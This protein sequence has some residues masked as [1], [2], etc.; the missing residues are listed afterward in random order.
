MTPATVRSSE[1]KGRED[2]GVRVDNEGDD[3]SRWGRKSAW[4]EGVN[5]HV[6]GS[7]CS[8]D[9]KREIQ[10]PQKGMIDVVSSNPTVTSIIELADQ[11]T[12][13]QVFQRSLT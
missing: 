1:G 10:Q 4:R 7:S 8:V 3:R 6:T 9:G 13:V 5:S 11:I 12:E 2:E